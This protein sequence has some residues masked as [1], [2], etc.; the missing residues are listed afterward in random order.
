MKKMLSFIAA[1]L[2]CLSLCACD[3]GT[4]D[5]KPPESNGFPVGED[6]ALPDRVW[7]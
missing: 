5:E 2:L 3:D 6:P 1:L 7:D 4:T